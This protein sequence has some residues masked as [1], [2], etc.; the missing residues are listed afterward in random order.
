MRYEVRQLDSWGN[1][2]DGYEVNT[3]YLM[4]EFSTV[5]KD[6]KRAFTRYLAK[7]HGIVFKLNRTRIEFDG[8]CFTIVNRATYEP[9]FIAIPID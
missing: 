8:D 9:L 5:A 2:I 4:G 1:K 6:E 7:K 3:S